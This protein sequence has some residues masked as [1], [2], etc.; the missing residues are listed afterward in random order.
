MT[1]PWL[2][3]PTSPPY[4][5]PVDHAAIDAFK[6]KDFYNF[7]LFPDPFVGN[8]DTAKAIILSTNPRAD[9]NDKANLQNPL[10]V[11]ES[12]KSIQ[13]KPDA[14]FFYL[15][16][17]FRDT[18]GW[19]WWLGTG[20]GNG[21]L[22]EIARSENISA[23]SLSRNIMQIELLG[24]HSP[25]YKPPSKPWPSQL[26][27]YALV[28]EAMQLHKVVVVMR[29]WTLWAR[30]VPELAVYDNVIRLNS[31]YGGYITRNNMDEGSY[32][33]LVTALRGDLNSTVKG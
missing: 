1:N 2:D 10:F 31:P 7:D 6:Y 27:S 11:A 5:A 30:T 13:R 14:K 22:R 9:E 26:Y 18:D 20:K 21:K 25:F 28:R 17:K 19:S 33:K 24:Y 16:D 15:L 4:I 12:L 8:F 23:E 32:R 29:G 3:L